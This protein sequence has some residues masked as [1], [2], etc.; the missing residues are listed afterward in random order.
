MDRRLGKFLVVAVSVAAI[1]GFVL[2]SNSLVK[3]LGIQERERMDIWANVVPRLMS[4]PT[5]SFF[6]TSSPPTIP[7][8]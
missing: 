1:I 7:F 5:W 4:I 2:I 6:S 3:Q 8:R